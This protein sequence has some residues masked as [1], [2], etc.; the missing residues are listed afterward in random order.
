[1]F[2]YLCVCVWEREIEREKEKYLCERETSISL[3]SKPFGV[4]DDTPTNCTTWLGGRY[5]LLFICL[6][7]LPCLLYL[8]LTHSLIACPLL[9][10]KPQVRSLDSE[11]SDYGKHRED[12]KS[13]LPPFLEVCY[14]ITLR[15]AF[16][17]TDKEEAEI[18]H[19][20]FFFFCPHG[21]LKLKYF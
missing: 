3:N 1:M 13:F 9:Y 20:I 10:A 4:R 21:R 11:N 17:S 14:S 5:F 12:S 8:L 18:L 6:P 2:I 15:K 7:T 16:Y 19:G